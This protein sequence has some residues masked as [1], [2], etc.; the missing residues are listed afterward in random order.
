LG[1]VQGYV[2]IGLLSF[3]PSWGYILAVAG[4]FVTH[5]GFS[6][7]KGDCK[8]GVSF[9]VVNTGVNKLQS[10]TLPFLLVVGNR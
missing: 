7:L 1:V 8:R 2:I 4:L 9:V 10:P 6:I 3:P 5:R